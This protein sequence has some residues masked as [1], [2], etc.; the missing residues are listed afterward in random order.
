MKKLL[1]LVIAAIFGGVVTLGGAYLLGFTASTTFPAGYAP[2]KPTFTNY[3]P[4]STDRVPTEGFTLAAQRALPAVVHIQATQRVAA[5]EQGQSPFDLRDLPEPFRQFFGNPGQR[6]QGQEEPMRQGTG[7]GVL[8]SPDGFIVT[9]NHVV[10]D[11]D[12]LD[13]TLNDQR[14]FSAKV[15]G[16]DP[17]TDIALIKIDAKDL[18]AITFANSDDVK[19]G[20]WVIAVGNPFNLASTVTAGIVSAKGRNINILEGQAPIEA[21]I[22]TDAAVNPGN[23]GGALVN[24]NGE[25][26]GINSAI[27]SPTGVY[28]G[29][30]FAVPSDIVWKVVQDLKEYGVV[31][32]G[33]LGAMIRGID[34]RFAKDKN[35]DVTSGVYIDSLVA[36][37]AAA[38]AGLK[39]GDVVQKVDGMPTATSPELLEA[40]GR[41]RPG[42]R[43][44][45]TVLREGR[46]KEIPVTLKNNAGSTSLVKKDEPAAILNTLGAD[47]S[48]LSKKE[49]ERLGLEGGVQINRLYPGKLRN[50]TDIR[51]GFIITKVDRQPVRT[52]DDLTKALEHKQ[53]GVMLEGV[54]PNNSSQVYYYAFG[55]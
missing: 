31:Q 41:H 43:V 18:P 45:L 11:A 12:Q 38:E 10:Q 32:R 14:V 19:V 35:L 46:E 51:E 7:S 6:G 25:L 8:I 28:A 42:D 54:Y 34:G 40:I 15:I 2:P 20:E 9:N 4:S 47:F 49:A 22:Q 17:S 44:T 24:I 55:W 50:Q 53:G 1:Y 26:I 27:A 36:N 37:S 5:D 16:A 29:Y 21:F 23:S 33:Y 3:S 13:V 52:L 39:V 48:P 30:A